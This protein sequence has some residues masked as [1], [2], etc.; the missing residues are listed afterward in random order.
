MPARGGIASRQIGESRL[1]F[2]VAPEHPLC[3][4]QGA[5]PAGELVRHR[6]VV[7]AD[8][9][10]ELIARTVGLLDGQDVLRVPDMRTKAAAQLAGLGIGH[11][12]GV[13]QG[14]GRTPDRATRD[15]GIA[16]FVPRGVRIAI[17]P[18]LPTGYQ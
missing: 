7:I 1:R 3:A 9:S 14:S 10:R 17:L 12:A 6:A 16:S 11:W 13:D 18:A 8:T 5:I 15:G 2:V 4:W